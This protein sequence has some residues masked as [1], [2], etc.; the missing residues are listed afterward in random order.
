[1][2]LKARDPRAFARM[3]A[4]LGGGDAAPSV[5]VAAYGDPDATP[6]AP[7]ATAPA[8]PPPGH[9]T[10]S[11]LQTVRFQAF[12]PA[13]KRALL[14]YKLHSLGAE[15]SPLLAAADALA[16]ESAVAEPAGGKGGKS[17]RGGKAAAA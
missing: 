13:Y 3:S 11:T 5:P 6:A 17:G 2:K 4:I 16:A 12:D 14:R 1:V 7:A 9:V 15:L 8:P 10:I